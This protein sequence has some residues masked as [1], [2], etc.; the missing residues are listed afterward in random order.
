VSRTLDRAAERSLRHAAQRSLLLVLG[1]VG[2]LAGCGAPPKPLATAPPQPPRSGAVLPSGAPYPSGGLP[3]TMPA[4]TLP[5]GGLP[6]Q[7]YPTGF[8]PTYPTATLP[9]TRPTTTPTRSLPPA[10]PRCTSG[11]SRPQVLAVIKDNPTIPADK[12]PVVKE[13]PFCAGSWQFTVVG[14]TVQDP[15]G[16]EPLLVVTTGRPAALRL[17]VIG[18]DVCTDRV[19]DDA[20]AGIRVRACGF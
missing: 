16:E 19:E 2:M 15:E 1:L 7:P 5:T 17:V 10:A 4:A 13:G 11:P 14:S 8:G 20:P 3:P 12:Q 9:T 6:T 18:T